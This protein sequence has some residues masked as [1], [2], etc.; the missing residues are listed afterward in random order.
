MY[1]RWINMMMDEENDE[2]LESDQYKSNKYLNLGGSV[3]F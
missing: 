3:W 2:E 1:L